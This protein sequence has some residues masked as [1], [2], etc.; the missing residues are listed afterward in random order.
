MAI[1]CGGLICIPMKFW[2]RKKSRKN[3]IEKV[4][5]DLAIVQVKLNDSLHESTL[6]SETLECTWF[7]NV[8]QCT[9]VF[10]FWQ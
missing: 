4:V 6:T 2:E 10:N 5:T 9:G 1:V 7:G 3:A 8:E